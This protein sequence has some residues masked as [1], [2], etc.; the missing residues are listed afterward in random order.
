MQRAQARK[1]FLT[2]E[3]ASIRLGETVVF[4]NTNWTWRTGEQWAVLGRDGAGKSLLVEAILGRAVVVAGEM[5]GPF[6][7]GLTENSAAIPV[8]GHV[9]M[10]TQRDVAVQESSFYQLRWHSSLEQRPRTVDEFLSQAGIEDHNPFEVGFRPRDTRR[11]LEFRRQLL[12]WL[13]T[14]RL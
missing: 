7:I 6:G 13:G 8:I 2:F 12:N 5:R 1:E 9:S 4:Q 3:N 10:R 14:K 11:F